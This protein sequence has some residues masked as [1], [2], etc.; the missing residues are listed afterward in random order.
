[1]CGI[2]TKCCLPGSIYQ[3][4]LQSE[5]VCCTCETSSVN[6]EPFV[7]ISLSLDNKNNEP[8]QLSN[9]LSDFTKKEE[10]LY[11]CRHCAI[12]KNKKITKQYTFSTL[13]CIMVIHFLRFN[14]NISA[15]DEVILTKNSNKVRFPLT[16]DMSDY[17]T[18]KSSYKKA[19]LIDTTYSLFGV[20]SHLTNKIHSPDDIDTGHYIA[21][22]KNNNCWFQIT[23]EYIAKIDV[24]KV[25]EVEAF[26][27]FY[28]RN[29]LN[30]ENQL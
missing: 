11:D 8:I 10:I 20:I 22:V 3:G 19:K 12:V 29:T 30:Y 25:L 9:L 6:K 5:I 16:L 23:D 27:L 2:L 24:F 7:N 18:K 13:P 14:Q 28:T 15:D 17:M 4:I 1:M 21:Y 26:I